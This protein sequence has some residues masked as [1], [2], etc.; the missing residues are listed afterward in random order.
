MSSLIVLACVSILQR[1]QPYRQ[2]T[3]N[4]VVISGQT[5]VYLWIFLLLLRIVRVGTDGPTVV[6]CVVLVIATTG[7]FA[8]ALHAVYTEVKT[9][10]SANGTTENV[11]EEID[12]A[13]SD[14]IEAGEPQGRESPA[15]E[16]KTKEPDTMI[17][18]ALPWPSI[19]TIGSGALCGAETTDDDSP[20]LSTATESAGDDTDA[21]ML[22]KR[23]ETLIELASKD[24]KSAKKLE[25]LIAMMD[26]PK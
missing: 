9:N 25:A 18:S 20:P 12:E 21:A 2:R 14:E 24:N 26:D 17:S 19:L 5:L 16:E 1:V 7:L 10:A 6:G 8:F 15:D 23:I 4:T 22:M 3:D 11:C 13:D